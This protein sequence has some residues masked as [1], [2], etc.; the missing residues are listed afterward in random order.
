MPED[1]TLLASPESP[2][3]FHKGELEI[4]QRAQVASYADS[5]GRRSIRSSMPEQHREF[6]SSLNFLVVGGLD[7]HD[8][9]WATLRAGNTGFLSSPDAKTLRITA[10]S[11]PGD[12]LCGSWKKGSLFSALG[13]QPETRRRNRLNGVVS[14]IEDGALTV[15]VRQSFGNCPKYIQ[16]RTPLPVIRL[17]ATTTTVTDSLSEQDRILIAQADTF[18]IASAVDD[19]SRVD[20]TGTDVS[21]RGGL[22]GFVAIEDDVL[23][24]PDFSGNRFFNT[25]GN[26]QQNPRAGLL[27][28]DF[29]SGDLLYLAVDAEIV[30][31]DQPQAQQAGVERLIRLHVRQVRRSVA[32]MPF[33]WTAPHFAPQFKGAN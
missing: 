30:W 27:F 25:L 1:F 17:G 18:F 19:A 26:L 23:T 13:F 21:H 29:E 20:T 14:S 22:P 6:F 5:I 32:A 24:V 9:P 31:L 4:Q 10:E 8:Q 11:L 3:P 2:S 33:K 12:P 15:E 16:S 28:L 7:E